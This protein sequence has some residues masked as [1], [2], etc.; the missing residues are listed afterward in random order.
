MG[1]HRDT[2]CR[3]FDG[4]DRVFVLGAAA[5]DWDPA[6]ALAPLGKRVHVGTDVNALLESLLAE[7]TAGDQVVLMSNGGF[8]GLPLLLQ[9][10][11]ESRAP[12]ASA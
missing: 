3:A 4:A 8:Q 12:V 2:L 11:L 9:R 5:L 1:V 10:A 7:L 6:A